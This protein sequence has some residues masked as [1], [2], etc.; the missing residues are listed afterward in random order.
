MV[1][2]K[3]EV[4]VVPVS[5]LDR[6][7]AFY[8]NLGFREDIDYSGADGFRLV[9]FTPPGSTA[10]ILLGNSEVTDAAPGSVRGLQFVV[11]D[12]EAARAELIAKGVEPSE[13]FHDAGGVFHHAGTKNRV[14][15]LAPG[16]PSY[17][18]FL[19]FADPD[20][21]EYV[22]Q[23]VTTRL[24]GRVEEV[25]YRNAR[26]L[27]SALRDAAAAHGKHEEETGQ[28]DAEWPVWY[29][30]YMAKERQA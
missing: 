24:P 14:P 7:K 25:V 5:D 29:A 17:G 26:D 23:E 22:L 3:L 4:I 10:S 12:I 27:E 1:D 16:R 9:H 11:D 30:D 6:A 15:G 8:L 20:G 18:S 13:I 28:P 2:F 21:N 19:T